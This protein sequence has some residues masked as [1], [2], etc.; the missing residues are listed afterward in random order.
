MRVRTTRCEVIDK[1]QR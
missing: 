1:A